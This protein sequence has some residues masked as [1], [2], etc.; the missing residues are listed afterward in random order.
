MLNTTYSKWFKPCSCGATQEDLTVSNSWNS[1]THTSTSKI[2]CSKCSKILATSSSA[3][4]TVYS[5][6][7]L[8]NAQNVKDV[9]AGEVCEVKEPAETKKPAQ[10]QVEP[11]KI[12]GHISLSKCGAGLFK[13][14]LELQGGSFFFA[15]GNTKNEAQMAVIKKYEDSKKDIATSVNGV[16][17][18][19]EQAFQKPLSENYNSDS[20][21]DRQVASA[22]IEYIKHSAS[23]VNN[24]IKTET[25]LSDLQKQFKEM[26]AI[27][28]KMVEAVVKANELQT[29]ILKVVTQMQKD[30]H[31]AIYGVEMDPCK[32]S[33][34]Q[35]Y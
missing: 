24:D 35:P 19:V 33:F 21:V 6:S 1:T 27:Q 13:A 18:E 7:K 32:V 12:P 8:W 17:D 20:N 23:N 26:A 15:T 34:P 3:K 22:K 31:H 30:N 14:T 11:N 9:P 29:E 28:T 25:L 4:N 2:V 16:K 5:L 10:T